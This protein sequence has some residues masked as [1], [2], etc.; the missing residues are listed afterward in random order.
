MKMKYLLFLCL[1]FPSVAL[2]Q[3]QGPVTSADG[4]FATVGTTTDAKSAATDTTSVTL[5]SILKQVSEYLKSLADGV[6]ISGK[7]LPATA[8]TGTASVEVIPGSTTY[9]QY[10]TSCSFSNGHGSV[11]TYMTLQD[12]SGGT[13]IWSG[14]VPFGSGREVVFPVPLKVP[15]A[16]NG[17]FVTN[18]TTGSSTTV[19]CSGYKST[20]SY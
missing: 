9:Y 4:G 12:G 20:T 7:I 13:G 11:S 18:V 2:A 8:M 19:S 6:Y 3:V 5:V 15:T 1:L 14:L 16:G 10:I 17:L